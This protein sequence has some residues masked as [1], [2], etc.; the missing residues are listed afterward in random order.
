MSQI[1]PHPGK[2]NQPIPS[3]S[4]RARIWPL[5]HLRLLAGIG[6]GLVVLLLV[7]VGVVGWIGSERA[8]H[9]AESV[10]DHQLSEYVFAPIT[11]QVTFPS[12]DGTRLA[13][14]FVPATANDGPAPTVILVH[15]FGP[16]KNELLPHAA[17]LHT[18]G[19]HVLLF[20]FRSR[21]DSDGDM[22]T[23]GAREPLDV[24]GAVSYVLTRPDVDPARIAVQGVSLGASSAI[25]AM[26]D[27]P[28][29]AALVVES[30]FTDMRG[31]V[32]RSFEAFIDLP[33]FPFAPVT[34]FIIEQRV[35][36][37]ADH[38]RPID[39]ITAIG[40]RPVFVIED[41]DDDLMPVESGRRLYA[42]APGPK[43]LWLVEG[44]GHA[45]AF[46]HYP[47]EYEQRVLAF[48]ENYLGSG[49]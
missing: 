20:D 12:A 27:D 48:Y 2:A 32:A 4:A 40:A 46:D 34:V 7:V 38:I 5:R 3:G 41:L 13:G 35:D 37:D 28:R 21:G 6:L 36:A 11:E 42:A 47:A 39:S 19:Y 18:A 1:L 30:P 10:G 22:I 9:R 29:I 23:L 45:D 26:A 31:V 49:D 24:R 15:G 25:M 44:S 16:H 8:V 33:S 17:Y 14:W 43:E